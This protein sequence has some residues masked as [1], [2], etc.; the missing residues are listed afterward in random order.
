MAICRSID[1]T[2]HD[3]ASQRGFSI[4]LQT[5]EPRLLRDLRKRLTVITLILTGDQ[6]GA[7]AVQLPMR[8][9]S[10]VDEEHGTIT[11]KGPLY[12]D[13]KEEYE[14]YVPID[15][16]KEIIERSTSLITKRRYQLVLDGHTWDVDEFLGENEGLVIA[17]LEGH[18]VR[19]VRPP[20]WAEREV[21]SDVRFSNPLLARNP[22]SSWEN[23]SDWKPASPWDWD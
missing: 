13:E 8:D 23:E 18:D 12:G 10:Y 2:L 14:M 4:D 16:A 5:G 1:R 6:V 22:V 20:D 21:T 17:E 11:A 9:G 7:R 3:P 19:D 15:F